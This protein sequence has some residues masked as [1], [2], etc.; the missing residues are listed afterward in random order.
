MAFDANLEL[1]QIYLDGNTKDDI[2]RLQYI[3]NQI[4]RIKYNYTTP[5]K[6]GKKWLVW[7]YADIKDWNDPR[8]VKPEELNLLK[9]INNGR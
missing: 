6:D 7:F 5:M 3:N 1:I 2:V 4:N 8:E 9:E